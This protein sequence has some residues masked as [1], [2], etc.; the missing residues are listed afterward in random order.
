MTIDIPNSYPGIRAARLAASQIGVPYVWGDEVPRPN[1]HP[2]FDCSGLVQWAYAGVGIHL[3]RTTF[4]QCRLAI[5]PIHAQRLPGDLLFSAGSDGTPTNPGHVM[6]LF[7]P[8]IAIQA[9]FTGEL[10]QAT[11]L[12]QASHRW[13]EVRSPQHD[14]NQRYRCSRCCGP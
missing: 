4:T 10:V 13:L 5:I 7:S 9:P 8:G 3:P 2:G 6:I 14:P 11:R 12:R 1:Q